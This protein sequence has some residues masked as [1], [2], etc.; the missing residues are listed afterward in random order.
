MGGVELKELREEVKKVTREILMLAARRN[1]LV[2]KIAE[3]KQKLGIE[4]L[5]RQVE[6]ELF[7]DSLK[8][9]EEIGLDKDFT[10]RLISFFISE[11]T[12]I[13]L[14]KTRRVEKVGL[15]EIFYMAVE[16]ERSGKKIIRLEIGEPDFTAPKD[17]VEEACRALR[18]G[19]SR[20]LPS[21]GI[22][23][24]RKAIAEHLN[25]LYGTDFKSENV[26]ITAGGVM[27][28]YVAVQVLSNIGSEV[29]V[30][31]PAWPLYRE[32][33]EHLGRRYVP[34]KTRL[35][36]GWIIKSGE[37]SKHASPASS[38]LII[39]YPNNPTGKALTLRELKNLVEEARGSSLTIISDEV[40]SRYY[41]HDK[42][43]PSIVKVLNEGYVL[44]G[45]F[46]K[47]W[48]MTG[49]RIGYLV[50]DRAF[51]D[52]AAKILGLMM[53][54]IPEFIQRAALKALT[55]DEVV[56]KNVDEI[57]KRVQYMYSKLKKNSLIEVYPPDGTFYLFPRI[58]IPGLDSSDF[59]LKLLRE[60]GVAVAPGSGFGEYPQHVRLSA[61]KPIHEIDEGIEKLNQAIQE[62]V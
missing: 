52:R 35:E 33:A 19:R 1:E 13:Q 3:I 42:Y 37:L 9:S 55:D 44:V 47:M 60:Y 22:T 20:Y 36:D 7:N 10:S 14:E 58:K 23:E 57:R 24:L 61:V 25:E 21:Y 26:L 46:S 40:Y 31:E 48:G 17:V 11:S 38:I 16:L 56:V 5:D 30:P 49:Y 12:K 2:L 45:S 53:T 18:E 29:L 41:F 28:I 50:G 27:A 43:S 15:R 4:V 6:I 8:I 34:I 54:C 59:A 32:I 51:I 39:N 62:I